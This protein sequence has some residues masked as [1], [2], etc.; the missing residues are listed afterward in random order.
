MMSEEINAVCHDQLLP[1]DRDVTAAWIVE[2]T[3]IHDGTPHPGG[4][5][6][7]GRNGWRDL[8]QTSFHEIA[9]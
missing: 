4:T 9:D 5:F 7:L 1:G 6:R 3:L 8:A 2:Q